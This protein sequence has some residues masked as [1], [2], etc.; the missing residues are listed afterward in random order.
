MRNLINFLIK[1]SFFFVFIILEVIAFSLLVSNNSYQRSAYV[2]ASNGVTASIQNSISDI[3]DYLGLKEENKILASEN[4]YLRSQLLESNLWAHDSLIEFADS[5]KT[6]FYSYIQAQIISNSFQNRNNYLILN[7]GSKDGIMKEMGV[8]SSNGIV[9]IVNS[10]S[11]N[12]CSVISILHSK[13]AIDGKITSNKYTGTC[14]WPGNDYQIG[15][16][17]NIPSHTK[18]AIGDTVVTSGNSSIFPPKIPIGFIHNFELKPG[19]N[20]YEIELDYSVDYNKLNHVY[21]IHNLHK[22]EL[23]K[24]KE[25]RNEK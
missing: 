18:F 5:Q 6:Q 10:V 12:F 2:T 22:E 20:F 7:K 25:V 9:G 15:E 23:I 1:Y 11:E 21:I 14:Y 13:S 16:L 8:I 17:R 3:T 19:K 4:A 24:I